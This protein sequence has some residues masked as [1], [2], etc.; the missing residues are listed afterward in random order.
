MW[1]P[2]NGLPSWDDG[3]PS[4]RTSWLTRQG[5]QLCLTGAAGDRLRFTIAVSLVVPL[6]A[7][8]VAGFLAHDMWVSARGAYREEV[9]RHIMFFAFNTICVACWGRAWASRCCSS[10]LRRGAQVRPHAH[11]AGFGVQRSRGA[12]EGCGLLPTGAR[13]RQPRSSRRADSGPQRAS[14]T[15]HNPHLRILL[16]RRERPSTSTTSAPD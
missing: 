13:P 15:P 4:S 3:S 10:S 6:L 9:G 5:D 2:E 8:L 16:R 11:D 1:N 12:A 14:T 7:G